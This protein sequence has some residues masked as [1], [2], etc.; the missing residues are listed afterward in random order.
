MGTWFN[1]LLFVH[2]LAVILA[3]GSNFARPMVERVASNSEGVSSAFARFATIYQAPALAVVLVSGILMAYSLEPR[4]VFKETWIS[5]A[6]TLWILI[7]VVFFFLIRADKQGNKKLAAPLTGV[8]HL[9]LAVALW[10]MIFQP[11][12][13]A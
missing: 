6:F 10:A 8:L 7:A 3:F 1:I 9:L 5:I 12:A 4:E 11:G 13:P 2:I